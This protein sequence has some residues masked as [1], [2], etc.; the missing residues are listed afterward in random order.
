M[1]RIF[2]PYFTTKPMGNAKGSGLGL[3]ICHSIIKKHDGAVTCTSRSGAGS[4]FSLYLPAP[5]RENE[6]SR[7]KASDMSGRQRKHILVM[8]DEDSIRKVMVQLLN[9]LGYEVELAAD[10][11]EAVEKYVQAKRSDRPFDVL[12]LDLTIRGGTGGYATIQKI[13]SID[14]EVK[15][16]IFSG[17]IHDPV[18]ESCGDY[19][20]CAALTK[21]FTVN[22][23]DKTL[24]RALAQ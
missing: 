22:E 24:S 7:Q 12:L 1:D 23:L 10:G 21:P 4:T 15:A 5:R 16:V 20:F 17:H 6:I 9:H 13:R 11:E 18:I 14:P 19:G 2:D 8:D 3:A